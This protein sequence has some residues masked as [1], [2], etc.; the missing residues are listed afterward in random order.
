MRK[1]VSQVLEKSTLMPFRWLKN[2]YRCFFCYE[3]FKEPQELKS[4][5][6]V[7][8]TD[9]IKMKM[10]AYYE[11]TVYVDISN[12]SCKLCPENID[13]L[14]S[15]IDHLILKHDV[16]FNKDI[17]ICMNEFRLNDLTVS[18]VL[19]GGS[20]QTFGHLLVHTNKY[21]KGFSNMLCDIC[22]VHFRTRTRLREH[23]NMHQNKTV[24]C[25]FCDESMAPTKMRTHLQKA[26][27]KT[28]KC[29]DCDEVLETHYKRAQ[30]MMLVH[31]K[32]EKIQCPHC[33]LTFV[34]R[35]IMIRHVKE[36]HLQE[37]DAVCV[38]CG[39]QTFE[40]GR[41]KRHMMR[42]S[43]EKNFKCSGCGKCFKTKKNMKAHYNNKH[44]QVNKHSDGRISIKRVP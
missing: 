34:F 28:Y 2:S 13:N 29:S 15:L 10:K 36:T 26:H 16:V 21:H 30:H 38:I 6:K 17:G 1:N 19:C 33:P 3:I 18:C 11:Y 7:H 41:M 9:D 32:R 27:N 22:G 39:W 37:K 8:E 20:Y 24:Q 12:I 35:S 4:H 14:Y 25:N 42:H 44:L 23:I 43:N 40:G 5:Q 31:N